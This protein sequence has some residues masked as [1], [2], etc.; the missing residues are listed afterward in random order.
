MKKRN[1]YELMESINKVSDLKGV[2]FAYTLIKNKKKIENEIKILEEII[3]P[4]EKFTLYETERIKLCELYCDKD[5]N[6]NPIIENNRYKILD[7]DKFNDELTNLKN[8]NKN[9]I[10]DRDKQI[11]EYN[12]LLMEDVDIEFDMIKFEDLPI[13][14]TSDQLES[15]SFMINFE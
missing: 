5:N 3:K 12:N 4:S 13:D 7:I 11:A 6:G 2:K 14:I 8:N 1:L 10:D 15:I 9:T